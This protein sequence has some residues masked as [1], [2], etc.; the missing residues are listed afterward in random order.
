MPSKKQWSKNIKKNMIKYLRIY[1]KIIKNLQKNKLKYLLKKYI[2][3]RR[4]NMKKA[5]NKCQKL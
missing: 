1:F 2:Y 5:N 4:R 3:S